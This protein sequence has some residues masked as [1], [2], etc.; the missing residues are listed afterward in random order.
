MVTV[1]ECHNVI[2]LQGND[3]WPLRNWSRSWKATATTFTRS[4]GELCPALQDVRVPRLHCNDRVHNNVPSATPTHKST[5]Q[6]FVRI[7]TSHQFHRTTPQNVIRDQTRDSTHTANMSGV[8][9]M[10]RSSA[11][12]LPRH[13]AKEDRHTQKRNTLRRNTGNEREPIA[14]SKPSSTQF[15]VTVSTEPSSTQFTSS[16]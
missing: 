4:R 3:A 8:P 11:H 13:T 9:R 7:A 5:S 15:I 6:R 16:Q 12:K 2:N 14:R 10:L 1:Q